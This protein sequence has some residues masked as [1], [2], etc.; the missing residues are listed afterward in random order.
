MHNVSVFQSTSWETLTPSFSLLGS[1][2]WL[3]DI[4]SARTTEGLWR[5]QK[6]SVVHCSLQESLYHVWHGAMF[7][8][9]GHDVP[10]IR[11]ENWY[12]QYAPKIRS[13][14]VSTNRLLMDVFAASPEWTGSFARFLHS[15]KIP[16]S[17]SFTPISLCFQ[18]T[19]KNYLQ[20]YTL[21]VPC[22]AIGPCLEWCCTCSYSSDIQIV[23]GSF[24]RID[25]NHGR[26]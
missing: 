23:Q 11:F 4:W 22:V 10:C 8:L 16:S 17:F 1:M 26:H 12:S 3:W 18:H 7:K 24:V 25:D 20:L 5:I 2:R 15:Q 21:R 14:M 6:R 19:R 9:D 13:V